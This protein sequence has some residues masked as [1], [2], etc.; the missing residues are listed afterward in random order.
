MAF[1]TPIPSDAILRL[2]NGTLQQLIESVLSN[3]EQ[4][5]TIAALRDTLLPRLISGQLRLSDVENQIEAI[6][7]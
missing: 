1:P 6:A 5:Q 7:A 3:H 4:A 2:F